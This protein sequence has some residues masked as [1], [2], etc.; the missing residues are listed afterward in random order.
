MMQI[1]VVEQGDSVWSISR[2]YGVS[3]QQ[4][5]EDNGLGNVPTLVIGQALLILTPEV[6]HTVKSGESLQSIALQYGKTVQ[7][8]L[9]NNPPLTLD[10]PIYAGQTIIISFTDPKTRQIVLNGYAYTYIEPWILKKALPYLSALT[11]FGYGITINGNL[12]PIRDEPLIELAK[13]YQASPVM[14]LSS[15]TEDGTF[16]GERAQMLFRN[17]TVQNR[18]ISEII[19][20]M[21][22]KGYVALDIDFEYIPAEDAEYYFEFLRNITNQLH[23]EGFLVNVDLAPKTSADQSGLLYESHNYRI[24]GEIADTVLIMTYE[25][26]YTYGPPMA[27]A[28]LN[29]V[30]RVVEYAVSEI[31]PNKIMMGIPNYGYDW[32]LPFEKGITRATAIGNEYALDI[33]ERNGAQ[34][35]FD[36]TAQSPYFYYQDSAGRR[37]VVWFE[38]VRSIRAKF[39]L[40]REFGLRGAGYWNIMRPFRQNFM[41]TAAQFNIQKP[42]F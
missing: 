35:Q 23:A 1:H 31:P 38:D 32:I 9:Q 19:N 25:W 12:I 16:S 28:P 27:V 39:G 2:R 26:G 15:I 13:Q 18:A 40:I 21:K 30:R 36:E 17:T 37:H 20:T 3:A 11:I 4:I 14:L 10:T 34:I 41:Y 7:E 33:A 29:N 42:G 6:T 8:L 22:Q 24:I 5:I